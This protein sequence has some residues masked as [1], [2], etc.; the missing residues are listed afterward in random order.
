M[1]FFTVLQDAENLAFTLFIL[2]D[3]SIYIDAISMEL[4]I[5]SIKGMPVILLLDVFLSL[6][7]IFILANSADPYV[8]F[9]LDLNCLPKYMIIGIQN[10]KGL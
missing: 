4:S 9:H 3:Y 1:C 8:A 6:K 5:L 2:I 10:E 7:T